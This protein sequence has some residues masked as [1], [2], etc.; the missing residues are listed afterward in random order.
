MGLVTKVNGSKELMFEKAME[1]KFGQM[2]RSMKAGGR[3]TPLMGRE[4]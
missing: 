3:I 1:F 2:G 4:D